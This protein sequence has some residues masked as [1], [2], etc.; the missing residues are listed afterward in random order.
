MDG[1][2]DGVTEA[3]M[4]SGVNLVGVYVWQGAETDGPTDGVDEHHCDG[5]VRGTFVD[6]LLGGLGGAEGL[7]PEDRHVNSHIDM[8]DELNGETGDEGKAAAYSVD[9]DPCEE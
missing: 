6:V 3:T 8:G 9:Q 7:G 5:C 4:T 2:V 1:H